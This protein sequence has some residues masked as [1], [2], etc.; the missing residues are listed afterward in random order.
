[1]S[2]LNEIDLL[3]KKIASTKDAIWEENQRLR[4]LVKK[5]DPKLKINDSS[6][7]ITSF[8]IELPQGKIQVSTQHYSGYLT[9]KPFVYS[10]YLV[11]KPT[12]LR[13]LPQKSNLKAWYKE[14]MTDD[15]EVVDTIKKMLKGQK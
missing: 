11:P 2:L 10:V 15:K 7:G 5:I 1:M 14:D 12:A 4:S 3:E 13:D 8:D 6:Y 9:D